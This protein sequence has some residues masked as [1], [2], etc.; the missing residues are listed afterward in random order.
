MTDQQRPPSLRD[1]PAALLKN[2]WAQFLLAVFVLLE[3]YN[4][5]VIPAFLATQKGIETKAIADNAALKQKAEAELTE[6]KAI[7]ET[8]IATYA[9]R[10][11]RADAGKAAADAEAEAIT[12]RETARNSELKASA[13]A[14]AQEAEA[15]LK[16]QLTLIEV[17]V[18]KQAARRQR[19]EADLASRG[20]PCHAIRS[21]DDPKIRQNVRVIV[22]DHHS[23][24]Y[25]RDSWRASCLSFFS[26]S[27]FT[28][29]Q[30][31]RRSK[32][33]MAPS[34]P[35]PNPSARV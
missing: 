22:H 34:E 3:L 8:G 13:E 4:L 28:P 35:V 17:E 10:K 1:L 11:Q 31:S 20:S 30:F 15:E 33:P 2:R 23:P 9:A 19:A 32:A 18:A 24:S 25:E 7:T 14:E 29:P 16:T 6:W 26:C 12:A 21:L 27:R 5:A